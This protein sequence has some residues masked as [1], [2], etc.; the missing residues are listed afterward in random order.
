M[1][2]YVDYYFRWDQEIKTIL[3]LF[4]N[5]L[6]VVKDISLLP[7]WQKNFIDLDLRYNNILKLKTNMYQFMEVYLTSSKYG[8]FI[9]Y[10]AVGLKSYI[11]YVSTWSYCII[12][13]K[14]SKAS[15]VARCLL[16]SVTKDDNFWDLW[17]PNTL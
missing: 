7:E 8:W 6:K 1:K 9:H 4:I 11:K 15:G 16:A 10:S 14:I 2:P 13:P 12:F 3:T 17:S 5:L